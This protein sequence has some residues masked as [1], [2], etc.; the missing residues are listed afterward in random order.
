MNILGI[1]QEMFPKQLKHRAAIIRFGT[2][3]E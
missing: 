2:Q 3:L 1:F